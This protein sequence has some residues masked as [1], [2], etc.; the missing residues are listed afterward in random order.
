MTTTVAC[1]GPNGLDGIHVHRPGCAD[2]TRGRYTSWLVDPPWEIEVSSRKGVVEAFYG[3]EA[4]S[5]YE[6]SGLEPD[7][8]NAWLDYAGEFHIFPCVGTLPET[9]EA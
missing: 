3:P 8:P 5:F 1:F 2:T 9:Q 4:G 7:D 6:E